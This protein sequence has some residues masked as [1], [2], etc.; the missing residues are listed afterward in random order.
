[1]Q[2][3]L[4]IKIRHDF[5]FSIKFIEIFLYQ[6]ALAI[7]TFVLMLNLTSSV[8]YFLGSTLVCISLW[9]SYRE[10]DKRIGLKNLLKKLKVK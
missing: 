5:F 2:V 1:M 3:M 9:I 7:I 10:L 8:K 4:I 6:F